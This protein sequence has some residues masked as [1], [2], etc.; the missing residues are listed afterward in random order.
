MDHFYR[1][2]TAETN[3]VQPL[4]VVGVAYNLFHQ[5]RLA[6]EQAVKRD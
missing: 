2:T 1:S 3:F 5:G 6:C 4:N